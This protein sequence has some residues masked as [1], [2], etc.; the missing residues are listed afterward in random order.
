[1]MNRLFGI[2]AACSLALLSATGCAASTNSNPD[3]ST[4]TGGLD[5]ELKK[6]KC[7]VQGA[8]AGSVPMVSTELIFGLDRKGTQIPEEQFQGFVDAQIT[9]RFPDGFSVIDVKG[10][11]QMS[12]GQIIKEP[13][14]LLLIYN[15]GTRATSKKLEDLRTLYKQQFEQESVLRTDEIICVAF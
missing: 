6:H 4:A 10:Q 5:E 13:S 11:Y 7:D 1:M 3:P 9:P 15:D 8:P 2:T 12:T 14:K